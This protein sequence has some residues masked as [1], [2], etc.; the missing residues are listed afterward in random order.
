MTAHPQSSVHVVEFFK[1]V[2]EQPQYI[3]VLTY[4]IS[5]LSEQT[6]CAYCRE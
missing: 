6:G 4:F 2:L 3:E 5:Q 1:L